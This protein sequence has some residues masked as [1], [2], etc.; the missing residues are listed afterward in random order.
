[1][2]R[3]MKRTTHTLFLVASVVALLVT[4][5]DGQAPQGG[6]AG[7]PGVPPGGGRGSGRGPAGPAMT[8]PKPAIA[9]VKAVRSCDSLT[10]VALPNTTIESAT[11]SPTS[12]NVCLVT[13][14]T[15]HPPMGDKVRI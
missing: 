8:T 12:P 9:N 4:V 14:V 2:E 10:S 3:I 13:A 7:A 15:T 1:M 11:V 6:R 5:A